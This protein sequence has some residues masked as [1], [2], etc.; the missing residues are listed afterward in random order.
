MED[1]QVKEARK[2][3]K[4][5]KSFYSNL[6]SWIIFSFFFI[7]LNLFTNSGFFWAIFPIMGWG[8][9][10]AFQAVDVFGL[11]GYGSDW[12]EKKVR[13]ELE[14]I[15]EREA[16]K[17]WHLQESQKP[18]QLSQERRDFEEHEDELELREFRE[19]KRDWKDSDFV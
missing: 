7:A 1:W 16:A 10:V 8:I 5:I 18:R 9:G 3:V 2:R 12:E 14:R 15:Q 13:E 6:T 17:K 4:K 11:P 19:L